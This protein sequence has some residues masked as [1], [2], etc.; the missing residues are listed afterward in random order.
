MI[1]RSSSKI[2]VTGGRVDEGVVA[3]WFE[4][5]ESDGRVSLSSKG[6]TASAV[7]WT[8]R[9]GSV[10]V[11]NSATADLS[12]SSNVAEDAKGA[13]AVIEPRLNMVS[14]IM[15][16]GVTGRCCGATGGDCGL[17]IDFAAVEVPVDCAILVVEDRVS[18]DKDRFGTDA[19]PV[20]SAVFAVLVLTGGEAR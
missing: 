14:G 18:S 11:V 7:F 2:F 20:E 13:A 19:A 6:R 3:R 8:A 10:T 9:V 5:R 1:W 12:T 16:V 15:G 4:E 17:S